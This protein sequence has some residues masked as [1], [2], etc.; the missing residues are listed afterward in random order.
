M[1][2]GGAVGGAPHVLQQQRAAGRVAVQTAVPGGVDARC[3][4]QPV[5]AQAAVITDGRQAAG[6]HHGSGF[7]RGVLRE[8]RSRLLHIQRKAQVGFQHHF[9]TQPVQDLL[10]LLQFSA[11]MGR[12]YKFHRSISPKISFCFRINS[13]LPLAH[14]ATS[15][16]CSL[17]EKERPSPVPWISMISPS[18]FMTQLRSTCARLSSL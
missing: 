4:L 6:L 5:H 15:S 10:H 9:H 17:T 3:A 12:Q 7:Q 16:C 11:V 13:R 14:R 1:K 8:C 2:M 18:S